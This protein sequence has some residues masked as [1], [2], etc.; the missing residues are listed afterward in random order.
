[1]RIALFC[2]VLAVLNLKAELP[3]GSF[4]WIGTP[5]E[6]NRISKA[7]ESG[8][9]QMSR[10]VRM[11]AR[12]RLTEST[13]PFQ[14]ITFT[15]NGEQMT[16]VRDDDNPIVTPLNGKPVEWTRKDGKTFRVSQIAA[17]TA[18]TQIFTDDEDNSRQNIFSLSPD[19]Q[20]LTLTVTLQSSS[21][22]VPINYSLTYKRIEKK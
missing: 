3:V 10:L 9:Q 7:V 1:M 4:R 8:A 6:T 21:F 18:I 16:A 14:V 15:R 13:R 12:N 19:G 17:A 11:I 2:F 22:T 20:S 5:E